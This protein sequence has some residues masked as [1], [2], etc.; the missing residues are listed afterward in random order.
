M[1]TWDPVRYLQFTAERERPCAELVQRIALD[2]P[3]DII[4]LGCGPGTSTTILA[5]RWPKGFITGLDSSAAMIAAARSSVDPRL[6]RCD[7]Q[8]EDIASWSRQVDTKYDLVFSNAALHWLSDH[9]GLFLQLF[10]H[11]SDAGAL[12][13]QMPSNTDAPAH[14]AMRDVAASEVWRNHFP[15]DGVRSWHVHDAPLYYDVLAP[16]TS[17][18]D[19]WETE[20]WHILPHA[21]AITEWYLGSGLRP[22]IDALGSDDLRA[23]FL[24]DYTERVRALHPVRTNG[25]VIVPMR[26]LFIIAYR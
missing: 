7:W 12:A 3:L 22:F 20:Y 6:A 21:E 25:T 4:D 15:S 1:P 11:V 9:A 23:Q 17:R 16:H 18:I 10:E 13:V 14:R 19:V 8:T 26:R 2:A 5:E 24:S